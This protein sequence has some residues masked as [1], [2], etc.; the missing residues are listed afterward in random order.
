MPYGKKYSKGSGGGYG[1]FNHKS[2]YLAQRDPLAAYR[3]QSPPMSD[4][5]RKVRSKLERPDVSGMSG[6]FETNPDSYRQNMARHQQEARFSQKEVDEMSEK[7]LEGAIEDFKKTMGVSEMSQ[8]TYEMAKDT[9]DEMSRRFVEA[10]YDPE[11]NIRVVDF[12]SEMLAKKEEP[13]EST[14]DILEQVD[15]VKTEME[16]MKN[17]TLEIRDS[18]PE[19]ENLAEEMKTADEMTRQMG[20]DVQQMRDMVERHNM[21]DMEHGGV[22]A[23][24]RRPLGSDSEVGL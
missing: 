9:V 2:G 20:L 19:F 16:R 24:K 18:L 5:D 21:D 11:K 10:K 4:Y 14:S 6:N 17:E 15:R 8:E 3:R 1:G 13:F 22:T 23:Q 7:L 12:V